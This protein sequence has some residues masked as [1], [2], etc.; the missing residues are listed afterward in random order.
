MRQ[1]P[2]RMTNSQ[3]WTN[4][5]PQN[6]QQR[7]QQNRPNPSTQTYEVILGL[8]TETVPY[9]CFGCGKHGHKRSDCPVAAFL[10]L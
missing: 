8:L 6:S 7:L 2:G 5:V 10:D 4:Q 9:T 3:P 1:L